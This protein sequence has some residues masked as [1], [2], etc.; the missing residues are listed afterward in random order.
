MFMGGG[1]GSDGSEANGKSKTQLK[2]EQRG[3]K[4]QFMKN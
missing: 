3:Q 4:Y 2:K 1:G